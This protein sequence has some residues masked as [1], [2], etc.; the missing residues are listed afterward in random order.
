MNKLWFLGGFIALVMAVV[1]F[2]VASAASQNSAPAGVQVG[3]N[4]ANVVQAA[5]CGCG[6]N[7]AC[8]GNC[9]KEGKT[10]QCGGGCQMNRNRI[11]Q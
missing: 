4:N 2:S 1:I 10:C 11:G 9:G 7:S 6:A 8:G 5:T 3:A